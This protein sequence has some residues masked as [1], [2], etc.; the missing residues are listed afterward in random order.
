MTEAILWDNDGVLVDTEMLFYK[1]TRA[2]FDRLGLELTADTWGALY[3]G[4]GKSSSEIALA[5]GGDP[6]QVPVVIEERNRQYRRLVQQPPPLRPYVRETLAALHGRVKMAI[7]TGCGREQLTLVHQV[8]GLLDLFDIIVT[9]DECTNSKPH[10]EPYLAALRALGVG[11]NQ[12]L[13]VEDTPRG[14]A[15]ARA[16][17]I[18]CIVVPTELTRALGFPGA[19]A[20]EPDVSKVLQHVSRDR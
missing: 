4:A 8:G 2:A 3:L 5:L 11:P 17:G 19:L 14:L 15:A 6:K 18:S 10:P 9:S 16:A 1:T 7:V 20:I 12:C 13:A